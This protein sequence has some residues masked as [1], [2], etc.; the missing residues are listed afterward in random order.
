M[1]VFDFL[2]CLASEISHL[3]VQRQSA[4]ILALHC[5]WYLFS[6]PETS[7]CKRSPCSSQTVSRLSRKKSKWKSKNYNFRDILILLLQYTPYFC[8]TV[9]VYLQSYGSSVLYDPLK[10]CITLFKDHHAD[11]SIRFNESWNSLSPNKD[12]FEGPTKIP[13]FYLESLTERNLS[14][15]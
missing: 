1:E 8:M 2:R 4:N 14:F 6:M 5:S 10:N 9:T 13:S 7:C 11:I 3:S 12:S 15:K